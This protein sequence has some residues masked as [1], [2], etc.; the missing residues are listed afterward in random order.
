MGISSPPQSSIAA[1]FAFLSFLQQ[2]A[3]VSRY[4]ASVKANY[5]SNLE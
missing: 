4:L 5:S 1:K 3:R 2:E